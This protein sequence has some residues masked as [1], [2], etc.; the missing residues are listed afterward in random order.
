MR[1]GDKNHSDVLERARNMT[2]TKEDCVYVKDNSRHDDRVADKSIRRLRADCR[3]INGDR[4]ESLSEPCYTI[5]DNPIK[6]VRI[7]HET[8]SLPRA[9]ALYGGCCD[10]KFS[11]ND[12]Q[13]LELKVGTR[14]KCTA[15]IKRYEKRPGHSSLMP[16]HI[17]TNG[18]TGTV[19]Q[20]K[21]SSKYEMYIPH[22][23]WDHKWEYGALPMDFKVTPKR[24]RHFQIN[25][26]DKT[27]VVCIVQYFPLAY[28]W[29]STVHSSQ[30]A[31]ISITS[32]VELA[33]CQNDSM[34]GINYTALSRVSDLSQVKL[35]GRLSP[36]VFKTHPEVLKFHDKLEEKWRAT[37]R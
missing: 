33:S 31:T 9:K 22:I 3:K 34:Y 25:G 18:H 14:V 26:E 11:T 27:S 36:S 37:M 15:N 29:A 4:F 10:F 24:Q 8:Y 17:L 19:R 30:G 1:T 35:S 16:S 12:I 2:I 13:K 23:Q 20:I 28:S 21:W 32:D 6:T 7:D 5:N